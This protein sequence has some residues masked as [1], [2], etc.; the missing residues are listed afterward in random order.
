MAEVE[1]DLG[2]QFVICQRLAWIKIANCA[3]LNPLVDVCEQVRP[4]VAST[5][6]TT[7]SNSRF[8]LS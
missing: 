2:N 7:I 8:R 5:I 3:R 6:S 1:S 4:P